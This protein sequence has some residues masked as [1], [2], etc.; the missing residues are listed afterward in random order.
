[1]DLATII[2]VVLASK[3]DQLLLLLQ[4]CQGQFETNNAVD[5]LYL[6]H[7]HN[8][9]WSVTQE[10]QRAFLGHTKTPTQISYAFVQSNMYV[11][12]GYGIFCVDTSDAADKIMVT[13][14]DVHLPSLAKFTICGANDTMFS[15]G[16][17]DEDGQPSSDVSRYNPATNEWEPAGYM[18]SC[19]YSVI[20]SPVFRDEDNIDIVVVGGAFCERKEPP[21]IVP[22]HIAEICEI[23]D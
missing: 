22:C 11:N 15:F 6:K 17:K 12:T 9:K 16:G 5:H 18:H 21:L 23:G 13:D 14:I 4:N 3:S 7:F 10:L 2:K 19:R 8:S 1:M 20:V